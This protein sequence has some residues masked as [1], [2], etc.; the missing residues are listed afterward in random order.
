MLV[1]TWIEH[2]VSYN[3]V[4]ESAIIY[5]LIIAENDLVDLL[6]VIQDLVNWEKL[7]L[8]LGL[9]LSTLEI[10]YHERQG[11]INKCKIYML[12][13]WLKQ[14]DNVSQKGVPSWSVLKAALKRIGEHDIADKIVRV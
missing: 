11:K 13:A 2:S 12:S 10:I 14:Q 6:T 3:D 1:E 9:L 5:L 7:G 4:E 8:Q